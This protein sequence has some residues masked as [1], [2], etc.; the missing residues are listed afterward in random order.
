M[1]RRNCRNSRALGRTRTIALTGDILPGL[2]G[3]IWQPQP[4]WPKVYE[5]TALI[6]ER[7]NKDRIPTVISSAS[8]PASRFSSQTATG[9]IRIRGLCQSLVRRPMLSMTSRAF[10]QT[11]TKKLQPVFTL[12]AN[13]VSGIDRTLLVR[14]IPVDAVEFLERLKT[15]GRARIKIPS[16]RPMSH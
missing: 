4:L 12:R 15:E 1:Q 14:R 6:C 2:G 8:C 11:K 3:T 10:P 7:R 9:S 13:A 5:R 16:V